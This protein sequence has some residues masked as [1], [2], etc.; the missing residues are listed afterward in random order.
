MLNAFIRNIQGSSTRTKRETNVVR[1]IIE[2]KAKENS[3]KRSTTGHWHDS[4]KFYNKHTYLKF[5]KKVFITND[6]YESKFSIQCFT[7]EIRCWMYT[8]WC[9]KRH[10]H[11]NTQRRIHRK[12]CTR[13][14]ENERDRATFTQTQAAHTHCICIS[15]HDALSIYYTWNFPR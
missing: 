13:R 6:E 12:I 4:R 14:N 9:T 1:H 8:L 15:A 2:R 10:S 7:H 11:T 3:D 5:K